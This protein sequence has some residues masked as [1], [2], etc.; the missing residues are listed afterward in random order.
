MSAILFRFSNNVW[1]QNAVFEPKEP[2]EDQLSKVV[3]QCSNI[4]KQL[5]K[6]HSTDALKRVNLGR[7]HETL[8]NDLMA[9]LNARISLNRLNGASLVELAVEFDE[10][11]RYFRENYKFY[12][13]ELKKLQNLDCS[14]SSNARDFY[15]QLEKVRYRRREVNYNV[16]K[17]KE[18]AENYQKALEALKGGGR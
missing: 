12:E 13:N 6:T 14:K 1:A 16:L 7:I 18:I 8:S 2:S 15:L 17:L 11:S 5:Q 10:N 3:S 9:K 4:K